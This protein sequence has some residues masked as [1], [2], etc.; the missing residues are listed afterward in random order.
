M[1]QAQRD[2]LAATDVDG[3]VLTRWFYGMSDNLILA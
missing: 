3:H 1:R 2:E